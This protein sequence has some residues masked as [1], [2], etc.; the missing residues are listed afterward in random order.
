V[1]H[2]W[3]LRKLLHERNAALTLGGWANPN[4]DPERQVDYLAA[5]DFQASFYL[6]QIVTHHN[7]EPVRR[8]LNAI[9][10]RKVTAPGVFGVFFYKSANPKTLKLLSSFLPVPAAEL[11]REFASGGTAEEIC[12][13]TVRALFDAGARHVYISNLPVARAQTT[14]AA[15]L[16][17][18][19]V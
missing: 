12:A 7:L 17:R 14:L 5:P 9:E 19:N 18:A 11:S 8:F 16:D 2:A 3:Q 13:R 1:E 10:R 4:V 15:I 6:T